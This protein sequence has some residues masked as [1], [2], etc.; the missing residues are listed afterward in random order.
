LDLSVL[1]QP[2]SSQAL[3]SIYDATGIRPEFLLPVLSYESGLDPSVPNRAGA[4]YYG[5]GQN[6]GSFITELTGLSPADYLTKPASYQLQNVVL[7]YFNGIVRQY[8][9]LTSGVRVY[10]AEY[11][12]ASLQYAPGLDDVITKSP[13][14]EY[15]DNIVF[16]KQRKGYITPR[17]LAAAVASQV[18]HPAVQQAIAA[19]YAFAPTLGPPQDP[20]WGANGWT[21]TPKVTAAI[22]IGIIGTAAAIAY[23]LHPDMLA[24]AHENPSN[25]LVE[26]TS[27]RVQSL[28]FPRDKWTK[29]QARAWLKTHG[30]KSKKVD[31]TEHTYRFRQ[32]DPD[33]FSVLRTKSFGENI[34]AVVGR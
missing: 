22:A 8:G 6:S 4:P 15:T 23:L 28:I 18:P 30:Y 31:E 16:D 24:M 25:E 32:E 20:V 19:A 26:R 13:A 11:M 7:P 27:M 17:D 21:L 5:I 29:P 10:Q 33:D 34:K 9:S 14:I 2:A 3:W 1:D 12:P